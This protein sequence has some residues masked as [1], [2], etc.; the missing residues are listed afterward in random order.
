MDIRSACQA[1]WRAARAADQ[2]G[3]GD[4]LL[5]CRRMAT[6]VSVAEA[7]RLV[8]EMLCHP[9]LFRR[10]IAVIGPAAC[11]LESSR[12]LED[13]AVNRG[14]NVGVFSDYEQALRWLMPATPVQYGEEN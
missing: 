7:V 3:G 10:K 14:L 8:D 6:G 5:D 9:D 11:K 1:I 2:A 13:F 4:I 12:F